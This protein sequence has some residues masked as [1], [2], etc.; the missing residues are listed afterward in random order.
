[1]DAF[2]E[3]GLGTAVNDLQEQFAHSGIDGVTDQ[4]GVQSLQEGL[5]D[6]DLGSHSGGVG[7]A[8]AAQG[9]NQSFFNDAFLHV[10]G[11]LAAALLRSA[12]ADTVGETAD[13]GDLLGLNP[14]A[15]FGNGSGAMVSALTDG[16]HML[17]FCTIN[18]GK[19]PFFQK[20]VFPSLDLHIRKC[21]DSGI[22]QIP[23]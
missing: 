19:I 20:T 16:A 18:H 14:L 2:G 5:A 12:P 23:L 11:Q 1:M 8:G 9:L 21:P 4:V 7:H 10:Q 22:F 3:S 6:Q 13:I 15:L 17:Y